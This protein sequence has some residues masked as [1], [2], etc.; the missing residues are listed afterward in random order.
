MKNRNPTRVLIFFFCVLWKVT[1]ADEPGLISV[2]F[3]EPDLSRPDRFEV[4]ASIDLDTGREHVSYSQ[5]WLGNVQMPIDGE[6]TLRCEADDGVIV[7]IDGTPVIQGWRGSHRQ[8]HLQVKKGQCLPLEVLFFQQGG[9]AHCRLFWGWDGQEFERIPPSAFSHTVAD[10]MRAKALVSGEQRLRF[11]SPTEVAF[12]SARAAGPAASV[13]PGTG[14]PSAGSPSVVSPDTWSVGDWLLLDERN[15]LSV[16]HLQRTTGVPVRHGEPVVDGATDGNFQPYISVVRDAA[17]GRWRMWYNT[18]KTPGNS[19]QSSLALIESEDGIQWERPHRILE[20]PPIQFGASVIDEGPECAD[21]AKRYKAA[22]HHDNGLQVA[23]SPDGQVWTQIAPGPVLRHN[24]DIDAID[25]DPLR[26][27]YMA[28][29]S[30]ATKLDPAWSELRRIPHMSISDDLIH[31]RDPWPIVV[32]N[33]DSAREQGETQFYCMA[34]VIERGG[35]LIGFVKVLRDDLNAEPGMVAADFSDNR[36]FA[37]LGYTVLAWSIDGEHWR[38][39]TEP[40][41]DRNPIPGTW[42]RAHAWA[43]EQVV[44]GDEVFIYY[45]GYKLGHKGDRFTTRQVGLARIKRDRYVGFTASSDA[46]GMEFG[47]TLRTPAR[48]WQGKSLSVNADLHGQLRVALCDPT[49]KSLPGFSFDQCLPISGDSTAHRIVWKDAEP[50]S[51]LG[52][53]VQLV[54]ELKGGT[55]YAFSL[56]DQERD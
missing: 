50:E 13:S 20:T 10:T 53:Q 12:G 55:V 45:G 9:T 4:S 22:W 23:T 26:R 1:L 7:R 54:F 30:I 32:P 6:V 28:F 42:D 19:M 27:R 44:H 2:R 3:H 38:R 29:V 37:G 48:M 47:G 49:G 56:Y 8:G 35:L 39:E 24:H 15:V 16:D 52:K 41:L 36:P 14:S 40:F 18:P 11:A 34:G 33:P 25:W 31:W 17:T 46:I 51:L 21:Q 5:V 43:D